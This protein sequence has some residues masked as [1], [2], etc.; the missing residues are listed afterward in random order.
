MFNRTLMKADTQ[1]ATDIINNQSDTNIGSMSLGGGSA[2]INLDA[3]R[4]IKKLP[5]NSNE[6]TLPTT[7]TATG[8]TTTPKKPDPEPEYYIIPPPEYENPEDFVGP[9]KPEPEKKTHGEYQVELNEANKQIEEYNEWLDWLNEANMIKLVGIGKKNV[10]KLNNFLKMLDITKEEYNEIIFKNEDFGRDLLKN[11]IKDKLAKTYQIKE[12]IMYNSSYDPRP[13]EER[14]EDTATQR[15]VEDY[16][17]AGLNKDAVSGFYG[18]GGGGSGG[19]S[20]DEEE[21]KRKRRKKAREA[22]Q[23]RKEAA[24]QRRIDRT[25]DIIKTI[26]NIGGRFGGHMLMANAWGKRADAQIESA[27][28]NAKN[29]LATTKLKDQLIKGKLS[30]EDTPEWLDEILLSLKEE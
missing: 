9:P 3:G 13:Y 16:S 26:G 30:N 5:N 2:N 15:K 10:E 12:D 21:E 20:G 22:A 17:K 27:N 1:N 28:I 4:E 25:L 24:K 19:S 6:S 23:A 7:P 29:R 18:G 11:L 8:R 14:R